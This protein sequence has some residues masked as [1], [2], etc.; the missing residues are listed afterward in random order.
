MREYQ[1]H[2]SVPK[3]EF[4]ERYSDNVLDSSHFARVFKCSMQR[5]RHQSLKLLVWLPNLER[6]HDMKFF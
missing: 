5:Y 1:P 4:K 3:A 2:H 6:K